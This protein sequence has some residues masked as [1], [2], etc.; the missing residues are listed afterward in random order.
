MAMT[1][2][3]ISVVLCSYSLD[4]WDDLLQAAGSVQVQTA[5][6]LETIVVVDHNLA[7]L[8][9]AR[10]HFAL[11]ANVRVVPSD[12]PPGLSTARNTGVALATGEIVAFL[13]DD[14]VADPEWIERLAAPYA[15]PDVF[16]V[17]GFIEPRWLVGRPRTFPPE[18]DWV[19]GC[20]YRGHP[21]TTQPIRNVIGANMSFRRDVFDDVGH[22]RSDAGR[23]GALPLGCEETELCLRATSKRPG[24]AIVFE[25]QARVIHSVPRA[26]GTWGYFVRRC[27][28]EGLSKAAL[29]RVAGRPEGLRI[30]RSYVTDTVRHGLGRDFIAGVSGDVAGF[31]RAL[32]MVVGLVAAAA[33]YC[34]GA[35]HARVPGRRSAVR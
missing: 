7:L 15:R 22:F 1:N 35:L 3:S 32:R 9:R 30:E 27:Y 4:R 20:T 28:G 24:G 11:L 34:S 29:V 21:T 6:P 16:A 23:I 31:G 8:E 25:P 12:G 26:R 18:F 17:G 10:S 5:P 2:P 19:V 33:G 13:D 14:A